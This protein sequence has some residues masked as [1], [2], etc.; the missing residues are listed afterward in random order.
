MAAE[1]MHTE[2]PLRAGG[3]AVPRDALLPRHLEKLGEVAREDA[4]D[5]EQWRLA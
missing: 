2:I 1:E 5:Q 4:G 3:L